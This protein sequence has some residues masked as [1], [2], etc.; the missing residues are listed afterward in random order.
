M[1]LHLHDGE[2][3]LKLHKPVILICPV[4]SHIN[5]PTY[6]VIKFVSEAL[7]EYLTL[8]NEY[9]VSNSINMD[10]E[11]IKLKINNN[12]RVITKY[13]KDL[14]VNIPITEVIQ[15]IDNFLNLN[16]TDMISENQL[17]IDQLQTVLAQ[18]CFTFPHNVINLQKV[19]P[20]DRPTWVK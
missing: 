1:S 20:R 12:C 7:K 17:C 4:I 15:V 9:V 11:P 5:T 13:I 8:S 2:V 3:K 18:N 14:Y 6:K 10:H 19:L 16:G